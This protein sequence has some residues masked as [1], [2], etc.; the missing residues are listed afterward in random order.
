MDVFLFIVWA[1]LFLVV[2]AILVSLLLS[3]FQLIVHILPAIIGFPIAFALS[4]NG[5]D[6]VAAVIS[7][8]TLVVNGVWINQD[9]PDLILGAIMWRLEKATKLI[10]GP[11][12]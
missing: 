4:L 10:R 2:A 12:R 11:Y 6:N 5:Y 3:M 8:L 1:V 7:V 9:V